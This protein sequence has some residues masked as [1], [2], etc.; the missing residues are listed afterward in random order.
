MSAIVEAIAPG[1]SSGSDRGFFGGILEG[2][3]NGVSDVFKAVEDV[4]RA[5]D[6]Y[7]I[8]PIEKDP[9]QAVAMAAAAYYLGPM[10]AA[11]FGTSAAVGTG[12]AVGGAKTAYALSQGK[13]FDQA[14]KEGAVAGITSGAIH[15]AVDYFTT[16]EVDAS[17]MDAGGDASTPVVREYEGPD[18]DLDVGTKP[19]PP[20]DPSKTLGHEYE[21]PDLDLNA[22][23]GPIQPT[24]PEV[25]PTSSSPLSQYRSSPDL[26]VQP[27]APPPSPLQ[28]QAPT[29]PNVPSLEISDLSIPSTDLSA[30]LR[31]VQA[32]AGYE[33]FSYTPFKPSDSYNMYGEPNYNIDYGNSPGLQP[34]SSP[35]LTRMGGGTGVTAPVQGTSEFTYGPGAGEDYVGQSDYWR[36]NGK[37]YGAPSPDGTIGA[38]GVTPEVPGYSYTPTQNVGELSAWEKLTR[39]DLGGATKDAGTGAWNYAKNVAYENPWTTAA[40]LAIGADYLANPPKE[41]DKPTKTTGSTKDTRFT[42]SLDI[43]NYVR[44]RANYQGD[45]TKYGQ[46]GQGGEQQFFKNER[47]EPVP[48]VQPTTA[49]KNGGLMQMRRFAQGGQMQ[50][51]PQMDPRRAQMM[52]AMAQQRPAG[53]GS[54]QMPSQGGLQQGMQ[55]APRPQMPQRP[56][57]PKMAYY[58]YGNPPARGMAMGGLNQVHSMKIGGGADG[59]SDDVNAVLS[60]GEYVMDA[61]T[62]AM[63]GNGSSKAGAAQLD[64]M[65]A[66]L[67]KQKGQALARGEI[68]PDARSPLSYLKG[69]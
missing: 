53:M 5:I 12:I 29:I 46:K 49:A 33:N 24:T 61:E 13:E 27:V 59:R 69:A 34:Q 19:L 28:A 17:L 56:R 36:N 62:V 16:P 63:L 18:L 21:G 14:L 4:G 37:T 22:G 8:E 47:F 26:N 6:T 66:N 45:L 31:Q 42:K 44:D 10:A 65:R 20:A 50:G 11:Q 38:K 35:S 25:Q 41:P 40:G 23:T 57:D 1:S 51:S 39:G 54:Q 43:Y 48:I 58:Q 30:G 52:Q 67:R 55:Q 3:G 7:V 64:Q 68:S 32:P 60:D 9:V 2:V 15:G